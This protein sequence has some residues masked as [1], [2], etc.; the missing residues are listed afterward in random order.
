MQNGSVTMA[1]HLAERLLSSAQALIGKE[2]IDARPPAVVVARDL[3]RPFA[4]F[5]KQNRIEV[6]VLS[7]QEIAREFVVNPIGMLGEST[8]QAA[9]SWEAA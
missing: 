3:R 4:R 5:L 9:D 1:P 6:A 7:F 8:P 2:E